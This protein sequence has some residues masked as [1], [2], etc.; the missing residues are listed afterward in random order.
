MSTLKERREQLCLSFAIKCLKHPKFT[1]MFPL[2]EKEH[3]MKTRDTE[4][5]KVQFALTER[6]KNSP[7][8]YMQRL[9]NEQ[10]AGTR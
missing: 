4:K 6:L 1:K 8:I 10:D 9:L 2:N 5:Y 3:K 7:V